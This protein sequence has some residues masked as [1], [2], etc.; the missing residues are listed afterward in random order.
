MKR[1]YFIYEKE[2]QYEKKNLNDDVAAKK[3]RIIH[4]NDVYSIEVTQKDE[5]IGGCKHY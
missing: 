5:P 3:L 1:M 2:I 4:F